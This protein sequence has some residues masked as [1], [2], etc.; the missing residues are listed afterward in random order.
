MHRRIRTDIERHNSN[1]RDIIRQHSAIALRKMNGNALRIDACLDCQ[2]V[3][4]AAY[5][6]TFEAI[7]NGLQL[8]RW[9]LVHGN[10]TGR[11]LERDLPRSRIDSLYDRSPNHNR[12]AE[13]CMVRA[14]LCHLVHER[15]ARYACGIRADDVTNASLSDHDYL[16]RVSSLPDSRSRSSGNNGVIDIRH[17]NAPGAGDL[18]LQ[19]LGNLPFEALLHLSNQGIY[20][21]L[22]YPLLAVKN[23]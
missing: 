17:L 1:A 13:Q 16:H 7:T 6:H 22:G 19:F 12:V 10:S 15:V 11:D 14:Q 9:K 4:R 21:T 3:T 20:V 23:A 18:L 2:E 8:R 5:C